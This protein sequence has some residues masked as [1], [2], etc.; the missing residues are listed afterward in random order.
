MGSMP[1]HAGPPPGGDFSQM[2]N[3]GQPGYGQPGYGQ[4]LPPPAKKGKVWVWVL[5]G[6]L[7]LMIMGAVVTAIVGYIAVQKAKE[8]AGDFE[9]KPVFTAA[10]ALVMLN[11]EIELVEADEAS[12]RITIREKATGKTVTVSLEDLQQGRISFT[13]E[14]GEEYTLQAQGEGAGGSVQVQGPDGQSVFSAQSGGGIEF[15][16]WVPVP[17]GEI[18][19][20]AKTTTNEATIWVA[21]IRVNGTV[22]AFADKLEQD[23]ASRGL[24]SNA[25]NITT[26]SDGAAL[27][28]SATSPDNKRSVT[29]MGGTKTGTDTLEIV[30]SASER[31]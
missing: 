8:V 5:G 16:D 18:A 9:N 1:P 20:S 6:C 4:P 31:P 7:G 30:F 29:A 27:M 19:N 15:P 22:Q 12:E 26:S 3:Q 13:N 11:P 24:K 2:H 23:L 17:A 25:K 14:Q 21:T 10:K 28:F